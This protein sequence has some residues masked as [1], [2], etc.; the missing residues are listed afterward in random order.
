MTRV[1]RHPE[2]VYTDLVDGA[3]LLHGDTKYFYSLDP[4]GA[5]VWRLLD[6]TNTL[7]GLVRR[8]VAEYEVGPELARTSVAEFI[9]QLEHEQLVTPDGLADAPASEPSDIAPSNAAGEARKP[10]DRPGLIKHDEPLHAVVMNPF[11][12]QLPLA[13]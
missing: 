4:V 1:Q 6:E 3:V 9:R 5:T 2:V 8:L 13:E 7:E 11:D 10:F 12:P